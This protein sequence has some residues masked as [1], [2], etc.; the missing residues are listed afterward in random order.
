MMRPDPPS[1]PPEMEVLV[2]G[3]TVHRSPE[4]DNHILLPQ[5]QYFS[6]RHQT[7]E[8]SYLISAIPLALASYSKYHCVPDAVH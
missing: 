6:P 7:A 8:Y 5:L 2:E 1:P 3:Y 4:T